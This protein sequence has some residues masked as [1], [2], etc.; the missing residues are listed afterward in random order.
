MVRR[1]VAFAA[2]LLLTLGIAPAAPAATGGVVATPATAA[3]GAVVGITAEG[4]APEEAIDV[5]WE[6]R[7]L[8]LGVAREDGVLDRTAITVPI[9][10]PAGHHWITL[11]GR[12]SGILGRAAV[13]VV[14]G[15]WSAW[16]HEGGD[17]AGS[18]AQ[19]AD[20]YLNA[21]AAGRLAMA[22]SAAG[23][24]TESLVLGRTL[25]LRSSLQ[26]GPI[27]VSAVDA[28][29]GDPRWTWGEPLSDVVGLAGGD[30]VLYLNSGHALYAV[31]VA[32]GA[33]LWMRYVAP[34]G[35]EPAGRPVVL[36]GSVYVVERRTSGGTTTGSV[37][38]LDIGA[39]EVRWTRTLTGDALGWPSGGAVAAGDRLVVPVREGLVGIGMVAGNVA[40]TR[41]PLGEVSGVASDGERV[42]VGYVDYRGAAHGRLAAVDAGQ[43]RLLWDVGLRAGGLPGAPAAAGGRVFAGWIPVDEG[44]TGAGIEARDAETGERLWGR[45]LP[46]PTPGAVVNDLLF[47][48]TDDGVVHAYRVGDGTE[49]ASVTV[50]APLV[51]RVVAAAATVYVSS[52][53]GDVY[54]LRDA[55]RP[56]PDRAH[57]VPEPALAPDRAE[58]LPAITEDWGRVA[59][60]GPGAGASIASAVTF[61]GAL[62]LG[63]RAGAGTYGFAEV[64]RTTDGVHYA[65]AV[66]FANADVVRLAAFGGTL[67]AATELEGGGSLYASGDGRTFAPLVGA[68]TLRPLRRIVPVAAG[69]RLLILGEA[70]GGPRAWS[71]TDGVAFQALSRST[72]GAEDTRFAI[73]G[74]ATWG[75]GVAFGDAWYVGASAPDGGEVWRVDADSI[76]RVATDGLGIAD[77]RV[78]EPQA[79][80]GGALYVVSAGPS[81]LEIFR[82]FDGVRYEHV[83]RAGFGERPGRNLTGDLAVAGER[84]VLVTGN[85]ETRRLRGDRPIETALSHGFEIWTSR[86][87]E[88]WT[89]AGRPGLGDPH[90][91]MG[92]LRE[93]A[94]VLYLA[95]SNHRQGD[96][97]WRSGDGLRWTTI[98]REGATTPYS[99]GVRVT[100]FD[101]HLVLFHGDLALGPTVWRYRP[102]VPEEAGHITVEAASPGWPWYAIGAV[103]V[104]ALLLGAALVL[105]ALGGG[106]RGTHGRGPAVPQAP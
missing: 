68:P 32:S 83:V 14:P 46:W 56:A 29:T 76:E 3:P 98:F 55:G 37:A 90:D 21:S 23:S 18:G 35:F 105:L 33:R 15:R 70:A 61:G 74:M 97:V 45:E 39:R 28:W 57:L 50:G 96:A 78:L 72:V 53:R 58:V 85:R 11:V 87:G 12:R 17:P 106:R 34:V 91:W 19:A 101:R 13:D 65:R 25:I 36:D 82:T 47:V 73:D 48:G 63:T 9:D 5:Y 8:A 94:G 89:R 30:G 1:W 52:S 6:T 31:D 64:W 71:S 51:G 54:A 7:D 59:R 79:V 10:A 20:A 95:G 100:V 42:F 2:A 84:L 16:S 77:D 102:E 66:R 4:F 80:F 22:W 40:W 67:Y 43:G 86:D 92:T 103:V 44:A 62:Y 38:A 49:V 27:Q 69:S 81:G 75:G 26:A 99:L 60:L 93:E 41:T 24:G 88:R 104:L